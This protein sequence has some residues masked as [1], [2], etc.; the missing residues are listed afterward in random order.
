MNGPAASST[1]AE[2][3]GICLAVFIQAPVTIACDSA[4]ALKHAKKAVDQSKS[5]EPVG[6]QGYVQIDLS[7]PWGS[8][9][10]CNAANADLR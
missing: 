5:S 4:N 10:S 7:P 6:L 2:V 3:L 9:I 1:R 8:Q